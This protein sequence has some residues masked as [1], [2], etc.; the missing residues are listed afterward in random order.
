MFNT[1]Q[2]A[3][4]RTA[5]LACSTLVC[6]LAQAAW[7]ATNRP[8][9]VSKRDDWRVNSV[10]LYDNY[11]NSRQIKLLR[12]PGSTGGGQEAAE[13][14]A[15]RVD[16]VTVAYNAAV[17]NPALRMAFAGPQAAKGNRD[18]MYMLGWCHMQ[19][20]CGT[21]V[22]KTQ[23]AEWLRKAADAGHAWAMVDYGTALAN[24]VGVT[25]DDA[26]AVDYFK[27]AIAATNDKS[28]HAALGVAYFNGSGVPEDYQKALQH[29]TKAEPDPQA[30]GMLGL[31][32]DY[33][34]GVPADEARAAAYLK[35]GAEGGDPKAMAY[36][37]VKLVEGT[38]STPAN[39]PLARRYLEAA[40]PRNEAVAMHNYAELLVE[41]KHRDNAAPDPA[42]AL[43]MFKRAADLEY[44]PSIY[45]LAVG[46]R[47]GE[48][49][50][51]KDTDKAIELAKTAA[52]RGVAEALDFLTAIYLNT[53]RQADARASN[54]RALKL[55][56]SRALLHRA[57]AEEF[58]YM[59]YAANTPTAVQWF[60]KA[61][62]AGEA[63]AHLR[64]GYAHFQGDFGLKDPV[65][66]RKHLQVAADAEL[67]TAQNLLGECLEEG[68]GGPRDRAGAIALYR[69]AAAAGNGR[70]AANLKRLGTQ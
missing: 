30:L 51:D 4:Q 61:A 58:G 20:N 64:L 45:T 35:R 67:K 50:L 34:F 59:G 63:E 11:V 69:L 31:M 36:Y 10:Y 17:K 38:A 47:R 22:D 62:A 16:P 39:L 7:A 3:K 25:L 5:V 41:G 33:G 14:E 28:G 43:R 1:R 19:G 24:G 44:G 60:Q 55:G 56:T 26:K 46:Y 2:P 15:V 23:A 27:R 29:F 21:P 53:K 12:F 52:D 48:M 70:A 57:Q 49:G 65:Q 40:I 18:G 9:V 42:A 13:T 6:L 32:Y 66:G 8:Q 37:G 68:L 54:D